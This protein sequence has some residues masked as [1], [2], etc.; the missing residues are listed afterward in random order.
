MRR[1]AVIILILILAT[2]F[3]AKAQLFYTGTEYGISLGGSQYFG[4]LNDNYGF[5]FVRPAGGVFIRYHIT[6]YISLK[7]T[8]NYTRIGYDDKLSSDP[9]A[10]RRNLNF[11]SDIVEGIAQAEFNFFR[12]ATGEGGSR[13]TPYLTGGIGVSYYNPYTTLNGSKYYLRALGTE[14][15]NLSGKRY[16]S[17][18]A[19]FPI[20][21]GVKY[22]ALPGYNIG[23]EI[24]DRLT[25]TD[26]L[27]DVSTT[28]IGADKFPTSVTNPNPAYYLQD[29]SVEK[30]PG[31]PLGRT[32]KQRGNASTFDQY[33]MFMVNFSF[34]LKTYKCPGYKVRDTDYPRF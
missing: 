12:F 14:G 15:Q 17:F 2:A 30:T 23:F 32:G 34:Q 26:Y 5:K 24:A 13:F 7:G 1:P 9:F 25:T 29:R 16:G 22:W 31:E 33:L 19:C 4:D 11:Q 3:S 27:D 28:Y 8:V 20:G 6:P 21:F 18:T 10:Q